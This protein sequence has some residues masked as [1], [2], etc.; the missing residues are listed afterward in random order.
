MPRMAAAI[1]PAW[2]SGAS[3]VMPAAALRQQPVYTPLPEFR[4][5]WFRKRTLPY[6]RA[7]RAYH[8]HLAD[9]VW[10]G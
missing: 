8:L 3:A 10:I 2:R 1:G 4:A 7:P 6:R 9:A 5:P